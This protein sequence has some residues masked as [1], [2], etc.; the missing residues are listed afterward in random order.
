[1]HWER[2]A[3]IR[4]IVLIVAG[5]AALALAAFLSP[6]PPAGFVV[7]G[8]GCFLIEYLSGG[9]DRDGVRRAG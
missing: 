5:V 1:M 7:I 4:T 8:L 2:L 3:A 6:W 9:D